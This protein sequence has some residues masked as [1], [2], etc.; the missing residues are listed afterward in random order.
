[1]KESIP[2]ASFPL[3]KPQTGTGLPP[4]TVQVS[5]FIPAPLDTVWA[6]I[7]QR[8]QIRKWFGDL[9]ADLKPGGTL[10]LDF[11]DA[12]FFEI[13]NV[14]L[15]SPR[16]LQFQWRFLGTGPSN[17]IEWLNVP[18]DGGVRLTVTDRE[19]NRSTAVVDELTE[20]WTDFLRRLQVFGASGQ[21]TRYTWRRE[22]D[23]SIELATEP[24][25]AAARLF[26]ADGL[27]R[28]LPWTGSIAPGVL[29]TM[30]DHAAPKRFRIGAIDRP[31]PLA[32]RFAFGCPQWLLP[33][34]CELQIQPRPQGSLL[35][36]S[37]SGWQGISDNDF[38]RAAQRQRFGEL[39]IAALQQA[40]RAVGN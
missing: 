5:V 38:E 21:D 15:D 25:V 16:L 30:T 9:S 14:V 34:R 26:A 24:A 12:D 23:G 40:R 7:T 11:G 35:V 37:H 3:P 17:A 13:S 39:W 31:A 20:G 36:V 2:Y 4:G 10:R 19:P 8:D 27:G 33:T 22:F 32:L 29:V 1:M 18:E 28:W 6:A